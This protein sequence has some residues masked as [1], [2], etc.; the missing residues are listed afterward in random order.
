[1]I[2]TDDAVSAATD[3]CWGMVDGRLLLFDPTT[4]RIHELN[5]PAAV[6]WALTDD[7]PRLGELVNRVSARFRTPPAA[8]APEVIDLVEQLIDLD[9]CRVGRRA[10]ETG[11][12]EPRTSPVRISPTK[13]M[14]GPYAVLGAEVHIDGS[15]AE[16]LADLERVLAPLRSHRPATGI[17]FHYRVDTLDGI[18]QVDLNGR[19]IARGSNRAAARRTLL[20]DLNV[21]PL[22]AIDDAI[23]LHAAAV[24][25]G[26]AIVVLPG[27]SGSGKSTIAAQLMERGHA[28]LT[29]ETVCIGHG[30]LRARA[31]PKALCL[32]P[33]SQR[34]IGHPISPTTEIHDGT[35]DV[36]PRMIGHGRISPGGAIGAV[37]FA[38]HRAG[39]RPELRPLDPTEALRRMLANAFSPPRIDQAA[40]AA[41]VRLAND[42]GAYELVHG[43][44]DH[45]H[46]VEDS[47]GRVSP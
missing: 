23:A 15:D 30:D 9:V 40:F 45:L 28:Y 21:T 34:L 44:V 37:V 14:I 11:E 35:A 4:R 20:S 24:E 1:M 6:V 32:D 7:G 39:A 42:V 46:L 13:S 25:I 18:C 16:M 2:R 26:G 3:T 19:T 31:H 22:E 8:I 43:G 12:A 29:D 17:G 38:S 41:I 10:T 27:A 5:E 33:A 36:D 47:V